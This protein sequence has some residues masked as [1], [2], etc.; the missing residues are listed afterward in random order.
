MPFSLA[1]KSGDHG[2]RGAHIAGASCGNADMRVL[3][4]YRLYRSGVQ[5][6]IESPEMRF[7]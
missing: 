1:D 2:S 3:D 4:L 6:Q 5:A 7:P